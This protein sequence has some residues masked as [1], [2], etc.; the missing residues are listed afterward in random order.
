MMMAKLVVEL[1][2]VVVVVVVGFCPGKPNN[3]NRNNAM[4]TTP[5]SPD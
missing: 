1:S 5:S 3:R 2:L 4:M